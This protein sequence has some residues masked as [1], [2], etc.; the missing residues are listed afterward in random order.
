MNKIYPYKLFITK[1]EKE[2][3]AAAA[4]SLIKTVQAKKNA[5]LGLATGSTAI[6]VYDY[7][8]LDHANHK[9]DYSKVNT[10][11]LDEYIGLSLLYAHESY[12]VFMNCKLF[13]RINVKLTNTNFPNPKNPSAYDNLIKKH[14]GLDV[15]MISVGH[16]G[17]IAFNEPGSSLN[18]ITRVIKLTPSTIEAN[19]RFFGGNKHLVPKTAVSMGIKSILGAKK[20]ILI[21]IGVGKAKALSHIFMKKYDI[22]WPCTSILLHPNVEIYVDAKTAKAAGY[23]K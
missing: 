23:K 9:T 5:N 1:G 4:K 11:N 6:P 16:N 12:R 18:S 10:F 19:S 17:H 21:I 8:A 3:A 20:I 7:M 22:Q 13:N 15:Q 14:G 2:A